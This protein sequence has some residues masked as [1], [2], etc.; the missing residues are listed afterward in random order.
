MSHGSATPAAT[1]PDVSMD[2]HGG[3]V[4]VLRLFAYAMVAVAFA[5]VLNNFLT[6]WGD[7]PGLAKLAGHLGWNSKPQSLA[8]GDLL[9]AWIQV[10]L[11]V[12]P[13]LALAVLIRRTPNRQL[14]DDADMLTDIGGYL[15]R[16]AFWAVLMI[17]IVDMLISF[18]RVEGLLPDVVGKELAGDLGRSAF[19]GTYVHYP[20][21][22]LALVIA[23]FQ[24]SLGFTWLAAL[25][26][27][28]ELQIVI[29][30]FIF[31]YE[32][33]FM[34]DLV[35]F[36]YGA[37]F[38]FASPYTL[39]QEGHVRVD[40]LYTGFSN[41]GKA[42]T[43]AAGS[44]FL[45]APFCWVILVMGLGGKA[46]VINGPLLSF[47]VTQAGFGMYV[48]YMLAGFLLIFALSM[49]IQFMSYLLSSAAVLLR[50][51]GYEPDMSEHAA[52]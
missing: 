45:G 47:E 5:F 40:I 13:V 49:L 23:W 15:I 46:N 52:I 11:Y 7:W 18:L 1:V 41:R 44:L 24:R 28:A 51:P 12:L 4:T 29:A 8:G 32:Q 42:W 16:A 35:R 27:F 31:S 25:I 30:R 22:A 50:E 2:S 48:K 3:T 6:Y 43:N 26:V 20:L 9:L 34:A 17:G 21:M 19:R 14:H 10:A 36:W 33:A 39:I 38:L 37:L